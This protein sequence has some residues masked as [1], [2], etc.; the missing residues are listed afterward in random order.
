MKELTIYTRRTGELRGERHFET[1]H[2][3][4]GVTASGVED[5]FRKVG[6]K[7]RSE[8]TYNIYEEE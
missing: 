4:E 8:R 3:E 5:G 7:L 1:C 2:G 6:S